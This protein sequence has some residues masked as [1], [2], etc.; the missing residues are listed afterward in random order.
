MNSSNKANIAELQSYKE[1][2]IEK[3]VF[4]ATL[5]SR[6]CPICGKLDG[7]LFYVAEA[8]VGVNYPPIHDKCRCTTIAYMGEEWLKGLTRRAR[9]PQTGKTYVLPQNMNYNEWLRISIRSNLSETEKKCITVLNDILKSSIVYYAVGKHLFILI[10]N[11]P[12]K[13]LCRITINKRKHNFILRQFDFYET[14]YIFQGPE[15]LYIISDLL[16]YV[17]NLCNELK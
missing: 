10:A 6:T 13:W 9:D 11:S 7:Q 5:D 4:V 2:N 15:Q 3:Y 8:K 17:A 16:I 12:Y 1:C 14:D